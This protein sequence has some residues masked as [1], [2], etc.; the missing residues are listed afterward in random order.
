MN[1]RKISGKRIAIATD[2]SPLSFESIPLALSLAS[3]GAK[4]LVLSAVKPV[5]LPA[6]SLEAET[7]TPLFNRNLTQERMRRAERQLEKLLRSVPGASVMV[8][9]SE[10]PAE[11]V[12]R[13]AQK[14]KAD[15]L[16]L[17]THGR[18]AF[19]R[20]IHGSVAQRI[21]VRY[22]GTTVLLRPDWALFKQKARK[23]A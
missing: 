5:Y 14:F 23:R 8:R 4:L 7:M 18:R 20:V 9:E 11:F 2:L 12:I 21:L 17:C 19:S 10:D 15:L 6:P 1:L 16:L 3:P 13:E 22:P